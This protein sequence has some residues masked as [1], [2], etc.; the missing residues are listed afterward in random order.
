[1]LARDTTTITANL[2]WWDDDYYDAEV[3][4]S[5][6]ERNIAQSLDRR[7]GGGARKIYHTV[8]A[9]FNLEIIRDRLGLGVDYLFARSVGAID[10]VRAPGAALP[11]PVPFPDLLSRQHNVSVHADYRFTDQF[12]MRVGY[13]FQDLETNDWAYDGLGPTSL[14]CSGSACVIGTG[15]TLLRP[16]VTWSLV[17]TFPGPPADERRVRMGGCWWSTEPRL[18]PAQT[19]RRRRAELCPSSSTTGEHR[20]HRAGRRRHHQRLFLRSWGR[21]PSRSPRIR[22]WC[23][24]RPCW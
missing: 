20:G 11:A 3:T 2:N 14:T 12:S 13:L 22:A 10:T 15:R 6:G 18:N 19:A 1:V 24:C 9:G 23:C 16:T 17:Y 4:D 5:A 8:G 7:A 21:F